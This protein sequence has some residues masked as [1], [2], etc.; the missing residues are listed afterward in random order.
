MN[1]PGEPNAC[2]SN[3]LMLAEFGPQDAKP[4]QQPE[5]DTSEDE[6]E[7]GLKGDSHEQNMILVNMILVPGLAAQGVGS[8]HSSSQVAA[9]AGAQAKQARSSGDVDHLCSMF[10]VHLSRWILPRTSPLCILVRNWPSAQHGSTAM[11]FSIII[12][13]TPSGCWV[14]LDAS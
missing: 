13:R 7:A 9:K 8:Y 3:G 14:L 12:K 11:R 5:D 1:L 2:K 4:R 6:D 10:P